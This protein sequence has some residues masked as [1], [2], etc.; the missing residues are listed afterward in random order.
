[1]NNRY[2]IEI[3]A[4]ILVFISAR[5]S[6]QLADDQSNYDVSGYFLDIELDN[7][8]TYIKGT[9][10][11]A[12]TVLADSDSIM[13]ELGNQ[14]S[15]DSVC[16]NGIKV[17]HLHLNEKLYV[18]YAFTSQEKLNLLISYAGDADAEGEDG[19]LFHRS[20]SDYGNFT[21]SLTE[22]YSS[23]YWYPCKQV[24]SDKAD[25][26]FVYV[27]VPSNLKA[28]SNGILK[29]V[30]DIGEGKVQYQW[31][32]RYPTAFYLI[33]VAVG[34]YVEYNFDAH[35][36]S[37]ELPVPVVNYLYNS[38]EYI[39]NEKANIDTTAFLLDLF[40]DLFL[41]YPFA[42][43]KY[44]HCIVPLGGG[45][46]HQTMTTLGSFDYSLVAHELAHQW[47]GNFTTCSSWN[48]IWI[49]EGFASYAE[50]LAFEYAGDM[51]SARAWMNYAQDLALH[52][53]VGSV[54]VPEEEVLHSDRIFDYKS[55][56]KKGA[57]IIHMLRYEIGDDALFF[58]VLKDFLQANAY[59]TASVADLQ[60]ILF[61]VTG[62]N[63]DAFFEQWYYGAGYPIF[64]FEWYQQGDT[65]TIKVGQ[66]GAEAHVTSD[67][68]AF[69]DVKLNY[70]AGD[71][72]LS[73]L[74]VHDNSELKIYSPNR[75]Y[76]I[77][78]DPDNIIL[79]RIER[80]SR[81]DSL[82]SEM[83]PNILVYPNPTKDILNIYVSNNIALVDIDF[84][85][86]T[87]KV[88]KTV[89]GLPAN[90]GEVS[91]QGLEQGM[92]FMRLLIGGKH[93]LVKVIKS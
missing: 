78:F 29:D 88:V 13:L 48:D 70:P 9:S 26:V 60:A 68:Y 16:V 36:E 82:M 43:E 81:I 61:D 18:F 89:E 41:P 56:Y 15:I 59:S 22:P 58:Q 85:S 40:S 19:A 67:F 55:T 34:E 76:S 24:L 38:P 64:N 39:Q 3:L 35:V 53:E 49:N 25:S 66:K 52:S 57:A 5:L 1:M 50:Y 91:L 80:V 74:P 92:Y 32:S 7:Q 31:E 47:F 27:T 84:M 65:L 21:Y 12:V 90:G 14:L 73:M 45:M 69:M 63:F 44:G 37:L 20:Y 93:E 87:G 51:V 33:S 75:I 79:K 77:D 54:Y 17:E 23:K 8:S 83:R 86:L 2:F 46:E 10:S 28:G 4:V 62:N 71:T 72:V 30:V 42:E 6:A 11:I